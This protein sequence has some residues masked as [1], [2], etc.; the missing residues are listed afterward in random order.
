MFE[1]EVQAEECNRI[2]R[3]GVIARH[4]AGNEKQLRHRTS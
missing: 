1:F 4:R 3:P 2:W